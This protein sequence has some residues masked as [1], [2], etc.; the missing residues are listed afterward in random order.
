RRRHRFH[1]AD[2]RWGALVL[3]PGIHLSA[4]LWQCAGRHWL[5]FVG[6]YRAIHCRQDLASP[7]GGGAGQLALPA[8]LFWLGWWG[9]DD[10]LC[11]VIYRAGA[12][13]AA[14][15]HLARMVAE[16]RAR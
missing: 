7:F 1:G 2:T 10:G 15:G 16:C 8:N 4:F 13:G 11:R 9:Q 12:Y 3:Y 6:L 5:V 14:G